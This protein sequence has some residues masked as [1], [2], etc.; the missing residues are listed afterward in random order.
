M[1]SPSRANF[2]LVFHKGWFRIQMTKIAFRLSLRTHT[3]ITFPQSFR[4]TAEY[5]TAYQKEKKHLFPTSFENIST[6]GTKMKPKWNSVQFNISAT[7]IPSP[8]PPMIWRE[9]N[10]T[11]ALKNISGSL[12]QNCNSMSGQVHYGVPLNITQHLQD[13]FSRDLLIIKT[14]NHTFSVTTEPPKP[15]LINLGHL[16]WVSAYE[17]KQNT[18]L[19]RGANE[20]YTNTDESRLWLMMMDL[21]WNFD[22]MQA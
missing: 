9:N 5:S 8:L 14:Q 6:E 19:T 3:R 12:P 18:Q 4:I 16:T 11:V 15:L 13:I 2:R 10:K 20:S 22:F 21:W 7:I 17:P 1:K